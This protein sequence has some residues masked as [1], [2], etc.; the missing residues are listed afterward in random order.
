MSHRATEHMLHSCEDGVLGRVVRAV[1]ARDLQNGG[2]NLS[3]CR[4]GLQIKTTN[5]VPMRRRGYA[6]CLCM[7]AVLSCVRARALHPTYGG[8]GGVPS[9]SEHGVCYGIVEYGIVKYGRASPGCG[10]E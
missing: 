6:S 1:F 10:G 5:A 4:G 3:R 2:G 7:G 9:K 8:V